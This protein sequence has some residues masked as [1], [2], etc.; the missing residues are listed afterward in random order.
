MGI[1]QEKR[2]KVVGVVE[3]VSI[4]MGPTHLMIDANGQ[5]ANLMKH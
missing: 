5:V 3:L 1:L 4:V 2:E